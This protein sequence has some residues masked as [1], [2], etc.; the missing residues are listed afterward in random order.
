MDNLFARIRRIGFLVIIGVCLII[1]VGLGALYLQQIPKQKDL[2]DRITKAFLVVSKPSSDREK[3]QAEYD[4]VLHVLAPLT[5]PEALDIVVGIAEKSGIDVE[6]AS[7]KFN[8]PPPGSFNEKKIGDGTYQVLSLDRIKV[9]GDY[10]SVLAFIADLDSGQ[11]LETMVLNRVEIGEIEIRF[12]EEESARRAEFRGVL[13]AVANMM[14]DNGITGIPNPIDYDD[15]IAT[16]DMA[17]FPDTATTAAVKGYSGNGTP[18]DGYVL[19]QHDR[20]FTG[21]TTEFQT[22]DYIGAGI[23]EYYYTCETDG[24]ARQF[25][26]PDLVTAN[27][28][29]GSAE[30]ETETIAYLSV[31]IFTKPS[32]TG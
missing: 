11:T 7:G 1:Y 22:V 3:L 25:D 26:G 12:G 17:A 24:T 32:E 16:N 2:E 13:S 15:F 28:Y 23:T 20:I 30:T 31:E 29:L 18:K 8:I 6:P 9:Q 10:N 27:E 14:I 5:V 19:Y 21:N 4:E